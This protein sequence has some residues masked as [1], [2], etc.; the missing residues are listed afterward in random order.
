[1]A[2]WKHADVIGLYP[3]LL[4]DLAKAALPSEPMRGEAGGALTVE[5]DDPQSQAPLVSCEAGNVAAFEDP[6]AIRTPLADITGV[7]DAA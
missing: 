2:S 6:P 5:R 4:A 3:P 1:M 7:H